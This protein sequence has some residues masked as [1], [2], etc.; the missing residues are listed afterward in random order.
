MYSHCTL[1]VTLW[2]VKYIVIY[3]PKVEKELRKLERANAKD[4]YQVKQK[5]DALQYDPRPHGVKKLT[6]TDSY[7]IRIG[8]FRVIYDIE[9][10]VLQIQVLRI[11]NRKNA[12]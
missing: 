5:I 12:Y 4:F 10:R 8:N 2:S 6:D 3:S 7:R 9:D 1:Y 11:R